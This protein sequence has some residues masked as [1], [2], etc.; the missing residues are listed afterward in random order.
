MQTIT[1]LKKQSRRHAAEYVN[2]ETGETL[3][4]EAKD[5]ITIKMTEDT[6]Y[7]TIDSDEYVV[8]DSKA[9][10]YLA[11]E[12]AKSD[13]ARVLRLGNMVKGDCSIICQDNNKPHD[14]ETLPKV[15]DDM[16]HD[17]FYKMVR[18]LVSKNILAY[19][20]CAPS[21]FVQKIYML[22]PYIARK[23]K[24]LNCEL[25]TFFKDVTI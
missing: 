20:V 1:K 5:G 2:A 25:N 18:K 22:N 21:G 12:L 7:F 19:C 23:R 24:V 16:S 8:F 3:A 10:N 14:S 11:K 17:E 9:I 6:K 13:M 15:L 4:S